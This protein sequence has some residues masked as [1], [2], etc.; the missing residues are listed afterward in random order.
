MNTVVDVKA[1]TEEFGPPGY[2]NERQKFSKLNEPF[3]AAYYAA[4]RTKIIFEPD[5]Q[6][7]YDYDAFTGLFVPKSS[8]RIRTELAAQIMEGSLN[9]ADGGYCSMQQFRSDRHLSGIVGHLRGQVEERD[10]FNSTHYVH[11]GN[12]TLKFKPDG[13]SFTPESFSPE[14]R[15]R[16]RSPI[17]YDPNAT[18]PKFEKAILGH[19]PEEDRLLIQKYAGQCLLG[20]NL[21]QRFLILDG[22]GGASKGALVLILTEIVGPAN[23]YEL[24]TKLLADRFEIGRMLGRTLLV[25]SDVRGDFLSEPGAYRLKSLVG[26]D[27]LAAERKGSNADFKVYGLFNVIVTSNARLRLRLDEDRSAWERRA[28]IVRYDKPYDGDRI[29]EIEKRLLEEEASGIL[30]WCVD[31]LGLLFQDY[32]SDHDIVLSENQKK[33]VSDLLSESDSLRLFVRQSV[34]R[35]N[36]SDLAVF[37]LVEK[38]IQFCADS[39]WSPVV[40]PTLHQQL[41]DLLLE[42]FGAS[43]SNSVGRS[44]KSVRGYRNLRFRL[45]T[46]ED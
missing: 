43:K 29:F 12:C 34:S 45:P 4:G 13:S 38:Y 5:E 17:N 18:C 28:T 44:G 37:E 22:V 16:N 20:R 11:L 32:A 19:I 39:G 3:W 46:D 30:N 35:V 10:F 24:R 15:S 1:I 41:D 9:W 23:I 42:L 2:E 25:G 40:G 26:G 6:K 7:F 21:T 14:H 33:R 27:P 8:D 31:G 36:G